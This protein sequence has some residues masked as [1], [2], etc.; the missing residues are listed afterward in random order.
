[1]GGAYDVVEPALIEGVACNGGGGPVMSWDL[2][3]LRQRRSVSI[4]QG[5]WHVMGWAPDVSMMSW[6]LKLE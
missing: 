3:S 5:V 6:N 1:M 4:G 2:L